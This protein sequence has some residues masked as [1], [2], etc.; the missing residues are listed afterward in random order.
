MT[1]VTPAN[2]CIPLLKQEINMINVN[3]VLIVFFSFRFI[4]NSLPTA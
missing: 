4:N 2:A 3:A 1:C